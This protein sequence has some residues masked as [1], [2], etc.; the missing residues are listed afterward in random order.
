MRLHSCISQWIYHIPSIPFH[1]NFKKSFINGLVIYVKGKRLLG[2]VKIK[3]PNICLSQLLKLRFVYNFF[4]H[5]DLFCV[6]DQFQEQKSKEKLNIP[7]RSS[8][9]IC[10]SVAG[11]RTLRTENIQPNTF[12]RDV[13]LSCL[14]FFK[15]VKNFFGK[16]D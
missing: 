13:T 4:I 11:F 1:N 6:F 7:F 5:K 14:L 8:Q 9:K 2:L 15:Y 10:F 12:W 3:W 16:K